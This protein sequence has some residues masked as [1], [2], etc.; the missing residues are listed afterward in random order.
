MPTP[1]EPRPKAPRP[2]NAKERRVARVA[3]KRT[4]QGRKSY[5]ETSPS[6]TELRIMADH[7]AEMDTFPGTSGIVS[8]RLSRP[9]A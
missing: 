9:R 7:M 4:E 1:K 3:K 5:I 2:R 6:G 8:H